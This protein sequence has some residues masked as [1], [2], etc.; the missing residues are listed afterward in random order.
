MKSTVTLTFELDEDVTDDIFASKVALA[1]AHGALRMGEAV[2]AVGSS[3]VYRIGGTE[4]LTI[5]GKT[6]QVPELIVEMRP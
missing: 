6:I 3:K 1:C 2:Y 4:P 5:G